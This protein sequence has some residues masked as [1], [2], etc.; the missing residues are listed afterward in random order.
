[1]EFPVDGRQSKRKIV[2]RGGGVHDAKSI[3]TAA[4]ENK[5]KPANPQA[6]ISYTVSYP[7]GY[8]G[9]DK[10]ADIAEKVKEDAVKSI[11]EEITKNKN[12]KIN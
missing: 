4:G 10:P 3:I 2:F 8:V 1:M 12:S 7:G 5:I 11:A 9:T 6:R